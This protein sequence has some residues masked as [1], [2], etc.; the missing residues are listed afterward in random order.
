V[1][2]SNDTDITESTGNV[3]VDLEVENPED[4]ML[5]SRLAYTIGEIIA[6]RHLAQTQAAAILGIDQPK[7]S[8]LLRG[9]LVGF[10][11]ER[12]FRFLLA[13]NRDIDILIK[14]NPRG[15]MRGHLNVVATPR[16]RI[17]KLRKVEPTGGV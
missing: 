15:D 14:P 17:Q 3:F 2:N 8:A 6:R 11:I 9:R 16:R 4:A 12:L 5:K 7:V 10:S 1:S 13:L